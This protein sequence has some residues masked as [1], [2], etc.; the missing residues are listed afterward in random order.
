MLEKAIWNKG[1]KLKAVILNYPAN[2]TG[3]TSREQLEALAD[4]LRKYDIFVAVMRLARIDLQ[5]HV[6]LNYAERPGYCYQWLV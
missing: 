1:I 3:I 5:A 6:S 4:V 2:P